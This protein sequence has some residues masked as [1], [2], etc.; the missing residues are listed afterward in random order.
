M[1]KNFLI[2][3]KKSITHVIKAASKRAIQNSAEATGD[4]I[5]NKIVDN[6]TSVSNK[7][8]TELHSIG[9]HSKELKNDEMVVPRKRF[10]CPEERQQI[11]DE[12]RFV[13]QYKKNSKFVGGQRIKSTI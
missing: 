4:L 6:L 7:S 1:V 3:L 12:L 2:V 10:I 8:P 9:L 5:G 11:I 13:C